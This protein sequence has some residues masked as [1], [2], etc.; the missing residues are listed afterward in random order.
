MTYDRGLQPVAWAG[1]SQV[2]TKWLNKSDRLYPIRIKAG[3][4]GEGVPVRD[5]TVSRQHRLL[6][7]SKISQRIFGRTE[8]LVPAIRLVGY[9]GI[10]VADDLHDVTYLHLLFDRHELIW[11]EDTLSESL[12][13]GPQALNSLNLQARQEI[14]RLYPVITEKD[15]APKSV[16]FIADKSDQVQELIQRHLKNNVPLAS[17][18]RRISRAA[19]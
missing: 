1:A 17:Y 9:P 2:S 19:A 16:R 4:L 18:K 3:A 13:V 5:L 6:V 12:L 8:V 10:E 11:A 7:S 15:F 14:Q